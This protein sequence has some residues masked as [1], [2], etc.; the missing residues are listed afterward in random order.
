MNLAKLINFFFLIC[1]IP[2]LGLAQGF[3][4][5]VISDASFRGLSVYAADIDGDGDMDV[6]GADGFND[7]IA[8]FENNGSGSFSAKKVIGSI[9][10]PYSVYAADVDR[11]GD[12]DVLAAANR[13]D[14]I[15]WYENDGNDPIGWTGNTIAGLDNAATVYAA[16]VDGD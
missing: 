13:A 12:M 5:N 8:W 14:L 7:E 4:E 16:D 6:L 10:A 15:V 9:D 1:L 11:D 3:T 2:V